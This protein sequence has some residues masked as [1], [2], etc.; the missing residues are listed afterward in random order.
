MDEKTKLLS[1]QN[2]EA[3]TF[4][5]VSYKW[6]FPLLYKRNRKA[7]ATK[8]KEA[9]LTKAAK[10]ADNIL[11]KKP[12]SGKL[13]RHKCMNNTVDGR[14]IVIKNLHGGMLDIAIFA[15][16][17]LRSLLRNYM[18][19]KCDIKY[20]KLKTLPALSDNSETEDTSH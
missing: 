7:V 5:T 2:K 11:V 9:E 13:H 12:D 17:E 10:N 4:N 14:L 8:D 1:N 19:K 15:N 20:I 3:S 16:D 18:I 6:Q